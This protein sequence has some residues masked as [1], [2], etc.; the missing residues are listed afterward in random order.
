MS[1][2][3]PDNDCTLDAVRAAKTEALGAFER[4][5]AVTGIGI[6][7]IGG[8][9]GLKVNLRKAPD[10]GTVLPASIKGV[11]VK[12]EIVGTPRKRKVG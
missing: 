1:K 2:K 11:P 4:I 8:G 6:T 3:Q 10:T 9:Y 7:R 5:V 12:V